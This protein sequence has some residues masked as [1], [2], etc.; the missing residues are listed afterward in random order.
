MVTVPMPDDDQI[1]TLARSLRQLQ[2][3]LRK[4]GPEMMAGYTMMAAILVCGGI[5]YGLDLWLDTEPW[6][7]T[8]GLLIGIVVGFVELARIVARRK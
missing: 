8:G 3:I 4:S 7:L 1:P 5:G 6:L 2:E